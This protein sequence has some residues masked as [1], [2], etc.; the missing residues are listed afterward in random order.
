VAR[1]ENRSP[2]SG[3]LLDEFAGKW[4]VIRD[5]EVV[6]SA[7]TYEELVEGLVIDHERDIL[8][9]VPP[10]LTLFY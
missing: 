1:V 4:V 8:F 9:A 10:N 3:E 7:E 5:R 6:K 2:V